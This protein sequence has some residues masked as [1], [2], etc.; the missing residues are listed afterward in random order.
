MSH[1]D[2]LTYLQLMEIPVWVRRELP[3]TEPAVAAARMDSPTM[4]DTL[5]NTNTLPTQVTPDPVV[6]SCPTPVLA[7]KIHSIEIVWENLSAQVAACTACGLHQTRK[8]TVF[9]AGFQQAEWL[10]IGEAPGADEDE[11]GEPFVGRAGQLL[12]A[13][14]FA[15]GLSRESVYIANVLKCR[16]PD[17]RAPLPEERSACTPFLQQQIALIRPKVILA[18][19]AT[20]AQYLLNTET[21]IGKLRGQRWLYQGIPLIATYHPAYLLR[22]PTEK[23]KAWQD[24]QLA[25]NIFNNASS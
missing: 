25:Q 16:P 17:N 13:M 21:P 8:Q 12:T 5:P 15:L 22:R 23:R 18:V 14:L 19:G 6:E 3:A 2:H 9:G 4:T 10:I 24:L 7:S 1:P 20:A 11:R